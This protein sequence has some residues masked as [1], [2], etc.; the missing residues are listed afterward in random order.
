MPRRIDKQKRGFS[1]VDTRRV[2][3]LFI[4]L[5]PFLRVKSQDENQTVYTL[6]L[7]VTIGKHDRSA[8]IS[9]FRR[10]GA[11][12][13]EEIRPQTETLSEGDNQEGDE[14]A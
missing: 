1:V 4:N 5:K 2:K 12:F 9:A 3:E 7:E 6:S 13:E 8:I 10:L 14:A 11:W